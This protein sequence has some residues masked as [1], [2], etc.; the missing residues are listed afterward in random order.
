MKPEDA[1]VDCLRKH[2]IGKAI[3]VFYKKSKRK[4]SQLRGINGE[5]IDVIL[6]TRRNTMR[7][8]FVTSNS[9]IKRVEIKNCDFRIKS[10]GVGSHKITQGVDAEVE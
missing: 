1:M 8:F 10:Y 2:F 4:S 5:I 3:R 6:Q 9:L 7:P